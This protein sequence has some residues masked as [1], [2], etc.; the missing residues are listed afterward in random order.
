MPTTDALMHQLLAVG[1]SGLCFVAACALIFW[2]LEELFEGDKAAR[3]KLADIAAMWFYQSFGLWGAAGIIYGV[4][5]ALRQGLPPAWLSTVHHQ[6]F[7]LQAT[8]ALLLAE[9][10][11]YVA[12]RL[13][14]TLPWLWKFHRVHHT[15]VDMTWS[16]AS[17]QHPVDFLLTVVGANLP[18]MLLGIDL[19]PI[20][21]LA[22]LERVYTV[23][24]H[25]DL[26][27][28]YGWFSRIIASPRLHRHHHSR[29]CRNRN[30]AGILSLLDVVGNSFQAPVTKRREGDIVD[31]RPAR[32]VAREARGAQPDA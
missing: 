9:G 25:S 16:A 27:L 14:H 30:Y 10:W 11:V 15:L 17:R 22:I 13:A 20:T 32:A 26:D 19:A 12:H 29:E 8:A 1:A 4:A 21:L 7:W 6:P 23:L 28:H 24:L 5:F 31:A 18:A 3:P 2:P